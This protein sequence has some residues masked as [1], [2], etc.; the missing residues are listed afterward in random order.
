M[1]G[2]GR[3][4][5]LRFADDEPVLRCQAGCL[6]DYANVGLTHEVVSGPT[7]KLVGVWT[8]A[9]DSPTDFSSI[10]KANPMIAFA[11]IGGTTTVHLRGP[12]TKAT[13]MSCPADSEYFGAELRLGA[14]LPMFP[15]IRLANL[16]DAVLPRLS[17]GRILLDGRAWEMPTPQNIDVFV[18]R[19]ERAGLLV[20]DP[21]VEEIQHGGVAR[22]MSERTAQ[23]RFVRSVG[24]SRR[25]L[26]AIE[27]ARHASRLLRAGVSI[28]DVI[29]EASY[30]DQPHLTRA[31]RRLI[32]HTPAEL[33]RGGQFIVL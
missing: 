32:G 29:C 16:Q 24:L 1:V 30:Y 28:G 15:P 12:E 25:K 21:L 23:S 4:S 14:Y 27:R 5:R 19:L 3:R 33:A 17:D 20:F 11:R 26:L 8:A 31:L 10:A 18:D 2:M 9:C 13:T 7:G 22:T 6:V